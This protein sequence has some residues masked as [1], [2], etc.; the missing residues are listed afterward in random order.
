LV[1]GLRYGWR[2]G[3]YFTG[4][5]AQEKEKM[6][7]SKLETYKIL[8]D[9]ALALFTF[10]AILTALF[11]ERFTSYMDITFTY[12]MGLC[13]KNDK[14]ELIPTKN[15]CGYEFTVLNKGF[16]PLYIVRVEY[17]FKKNNK[18][19]LLC[20]EPLL[21][22]PTNLRKFVIDHRRIFPDTNDQENREIILYFST[23]FNTHKIKTKTTIRK[24]REIMKTSQKLYLNYQIDPSSEN[25]DKLYDSI[26]MYY[27]EE[28]ILPDYFKREIVGEDNSEE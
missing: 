14:D 13:F 12:G 6:G 3:T 4:H 26:K 7:R 28:D 10:L 9:T 16:T 5:H 21:I 25:G 23:A 1:S 27:H 17:S 2:W 20:N 22:Q 8:L 11:K 18:R 15:F 19:Y 24:M